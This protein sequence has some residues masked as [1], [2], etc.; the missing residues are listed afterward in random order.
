MRNKR[1]LLFTALALIALTI[2]TTVSLGGARLFAT[3][4][5]GGWFAGL[6]SSDILQRI[7][8]P[9]S[10]DRL[11]DQRGDAPITDPVQ[12]D[13]LAGVMADLYSLPFVD[14]EEVLAGAFNGDPAGLAAIQAYMDAAGFDAAALEA[15]ANH[16]FDILEAD[17][18]SK[19]TAEDIRRAARRILNAAR[20]AGKNA[21]IFPAMIYNGYSAADD[22]DAWDVGLKRNPGYGNFAKASNRSGFLSGKVLE[23]F[24]NE[25]GQGFLSDGARAYDGLRIAR[26]RKGD[27]RVFAIAQPKGE[28]GKPAAL[29]FGYRI[30]QNGQPYRIVDGRKASGTPWVSLSDKAITYHGADGPSV[31]KSIVDGST[32][33]SQ[34]GTTAEDN[35]SPNEKGRT[36]Q[37]LNGETL[38][39]A[40]E[41]QDASEAVILSLPANRVAGSIQLEFEQYKN[42]FTIL[43]AFMVGPDTMAPA[44]ERIAERARRLINIGPYIAGSSDP[45]QKSRP[46]TGFIAVDI[47]DY[48][49]ALGGAMSGTT[50]GLRDLAHYLDAAGGDLERLEARTFALVEGLAARRSIDDFLTL[51]E[52]A[53]RITDQAAKATATTYL[54]HGFIGGD[55]DLPP[56]H[57]GWDFGTDDTPP[58]MQFEGGENTSEI[59]IG[60]NVRMGANP[61]QV[62]LVQEF[63][64]RA[65]GMRFRVKSGYYRFLTLASPIGVVSPATPLGDAM[66]INGVDQR[67][68]DL[69]ETT[70]WAGLTGGAITFNGGLERYGP[71]DP[72]LQGL[73]DDAD[74]YAPL[75]DLYMRGGVFTK[76]PPTGQDILPG[77]ALSPGNRNTYVYASRA[78]VNTDG[79]LVDLPSPP[80]GGTI[81]GAVILGESD[82]EPFAKRLAERIAELL[83]ETTPAAGTDFT[84]L[85]PSTGIVFAD[86]FSLPVQVATNL[87]AQ[88]RISSGNPVG[89]IG[90]GALPTSFVDN[91]SDGGTGTDTDGGT[92][93]D[94]DGGTGTDTDG[95]TGTDTDGGTGT[96]TDSGTGT[97]TDGGTGTDT[98]GGTGTD[99]DGGTGTDTDGGTGTDTDG[100]T[101]TDTDGGT[102]TDT[103]GGTGTDTDG[104][105]GTDT[106]GGTGTDTDGGTGTDTDGG[107]GTDTDGGTGTDTDGGTGTD[108]DGGTGTDTDGG[109][110]TD[111]DGGTG[112]DTD[113]GTGTDTD[114]GTGTDTDGGTGTDTDGGTGTDTDGGTGTD[115]D[116]GTGTDTD[117]G[118]GT[119]KDGGTGTDTDGGTGTDTDGGTGTDTDGGTGTDTDGGTGT[120]TDGGTG[121]DTDGGTGTDT[122]GGTGTDTD[123]G[124]GTDTDGGTGTDTDGGTGTDTDGGTGTDTDGGTGTDTDGGTGT[125]TDGGTGTDTDGGTGTDTDGGTGTD[126]DGGT[127][128]DTD[129]GTGTDTDGGTGTDTD[130]GTGTDTD[131][132]TGTDT[133]GGTGTDSD[134]GTGT[135]TDGG[136]GT[137]T[138]GGSGTDTDGGTGTDT[139]GGTGT[140]TDGGT[141]TDSDGGTGTD[142]DGGTGT[143]TDGGTGTDTDGGTGT[144]TDGGTGTDTDGGTGTDTDGGEVILAPDAG[145]PY[146]VNVGEEFSFDG[147]GSFFNIGL[148]EFDIEW[149]L[150]D[151]SGNDILFVTGLGVPGSPQ[152]P[153]FI[154]LDTPGLY[155]VTL[156]FTFG[157]LIA[158][159]QGLVIVIGDVAIPGPAAILIFLPGV[160][161]LMLTRRIR[162]QNRQNTPL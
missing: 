154:S 26:A 96:D 81:I 55:F 28:T 146:T 130:G 150:E 34:T 9:G 54:M 60:A 118:T 74:I 45:T 99:T 113:G 110:G 101:G 62:P 41:R 115:T 137:D 38:S 2:G 1:T 103:D 116:G 64:S 117:G 73:L 104:G 140:D 8:Q 85:M 61:I 124:T 77:T 142:T 3:G 83:R 87:N 120:D 84:E 107:T 105:T 47:V 17:D 148:D 21:F 11:A 4:G 39:E 31:Q 15:R 75:R 151:A 6:L 126:T 50:G 119:D 57:I 157:D 14:D 106:D 82:P 98:D 42:E 136:T 48:P 143:D 24:G 129:G 111:T 135:D 86:A 128:T 80:L 160:L 20:V 13:D 121:T 122:D 72:R 133:D 90:G 159:D 68:R 152:D 156:T 33:P 145:G 114:G 139:D 40:R 10:D 109:T 63:V 19:Y 131:G 36:V 112:T 155:D 25:N 12:A 32:T 59:L 46:G 16:L 132:G 94:T 76:L 7:M 93:T 37:G 158:S 147:T 66:L 161:G 52:A 123:G 29:P 141:G 108:T 35:G 127:G 138:D 88:T 79:M 69:R 53:N 43:N 30:S 23:F 71:V 91:G 102:G 18:G 134:G 149:L 95:G 56:P 92:G 89:P 44:I 78:F 27:F 51:A 125:D 49:T 58:H 97:D 144:D 70:V 100:G 67:L 162:R 153:P 65:E 22:T 5:D